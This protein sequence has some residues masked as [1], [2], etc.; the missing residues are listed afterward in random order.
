[1][2]TQCS[3]WMRE[4]RLNEMG[5]DSLLH[6]TY[7]NFIDNSGSRSYSILRY[8]AALS[9]YVKIFC[10]PDIT[11]HGVYTCDHNN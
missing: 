8:P 6:V 3:E 9:G 1:M 4:S 7:Y 10:D 11:Y 2:S 5:R